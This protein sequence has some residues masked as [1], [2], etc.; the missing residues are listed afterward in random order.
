MDVN[1]TFED[2]MDRLGRD[3]SFLGRVLGDVLREQGGNGLFDAVEG[4]RTACRH[5]RQYHCGEAA[6]EVA[7]LVAAL[8]LERALDVARAFTMY[9]HLINIAE[10]NHRVRRLSERESASYPTP[11][12]ESI[13]SALAAFREA[14]VPAHTVET[15]LKGLAIRP[16]FTAH[17]TEARRMTLLR[18]LQRIA[19]LV[20]AYD[21]VSGPQ[22]QRRLTDRLYAEI[23]DLWQT[24]ELRMRQQ[25]P[26]DEVRNGLYYFDNSVVEVTAGMYREL[27]DA[28][29][30]FYPSLGAVVPAFL[31]FG[32]WIGGDRDGNANITP[33][34]TETTLR[35]QRALIL[36]KY[37]DSV[38]KLINLLT[39]SVRLTGCSDEIREWL[40]REEDVFGEGSQDVARRWQDEP[41]RQ[42]LSF[43]LMRLKNTHARNATNWEVHSE[44]GA[45]DERGPVY[46]SA[47]DF[48]SD[49]QRIDASLR[50]HG[51]ARV[52]D[53]ALQ[54]LRWQVRAFGFHL[55]GLEVRQHSDRHTT[56]LAELLSESGFA[57]LDEDDRVA[58]LERELL[59]PSGAIDYATVSEGTRETLELFNVIRRMQDELGQEAVNTYIIS[60]TTRASDVLAVLYLAGRSGLCDLGGAWSR[61][62]VVPLFETAED[63]EAAPRIMVRLY[64]SDA[65]RRQLQAWSG[66]QEI[67]LGYSDSDKDAGYVSSNVWLYRAQQSLCR[68]SSDAGVELTFF[69]GRG[70]AIGRGGG[71]LQR[72]ILGQ[73]A[74]TVGGRI[75]VT[76]QG[77]VLFTRYANPGIAHRHLEQLVNAVLRASAPLAA[78]N[79]DIEKWE[80]AAETLSA[81]AAHSYK[82][83][84]SNDPGFLRFFD[85]GTPL[86]SIMRLRIASRPAKR[87]T[88]DLKLEDL[89]AIPWV[90]SWTQARWGVP[91]WYGLGS[92]LQTRI[93]DGNIAMLQDMYRAWP[94]FRWLLDAAQISL[95]KADLGIASAYGALITDDAI[96]ERY[97]RALQEEFERTVRTVNAVIGQEHLL[98]S[99]PVLE[100]SIELRNP[101]VDPLSYIQIRCLQ[102]V[103]SDPEGPLS[104]LLRSIIDRSV[105]GVA[106]GLQNTG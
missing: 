102:E 11:R 37:I 99:W 28:V 73:P 81:S 65:Y 94:F 106:A 69:H 74:G 85:E 27:R 95:G 64:E 43:A 57:D 29:R 5:H 12:S 14:G 3:V 60:F 103:R 13:R 20:H 48:Q 77:E 39:V 80:E 41:Y 42:A 89:R 30:E 2:S 44:A 46:E 52:A 71:P 105:T 104:D 26:I 7:A 96:R 87:R 21:T 58:L 6:E 49:L 55:A 84:V 92:A 33:Q 8:P 25:M 10:E 9:F 61:L 16:V 38:Q 45:G 83:L 88:G 31:T 59:Q 67:M 54:D 78:Q 47:L 93:D 18:Q 36:S 66:R 50:A 75:K 62:K 97:S 4:L 24:N 101:Y 76:E 56:A 86:R 53:D 35:M 70:G 15:L 98:D 17:P 32:S 23:T 68:V 63:L 91:G 72:A 82:G 22:E 19:T 1:S 34:V 51:G 79:P 100:R 40:R 90:F